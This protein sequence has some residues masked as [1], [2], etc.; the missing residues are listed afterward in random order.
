[1]S[2]RCAIRKKEQGGPKTVWR[3]ARWAGLD[4]NA[5][6]GLEPADKH[7][8]EVARRR[9]IAD[10]YVTPRKKMLQA[11]LLNSSMTIILRPAH[12][13]SLCTFVASKP[14]RAPCIFVNL[15]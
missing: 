5:W 9:G 15:P 14:S 4:L 1:M 2:L 8:R 12:G 10:F 11:F 13:F 3:A 6:L 7:R